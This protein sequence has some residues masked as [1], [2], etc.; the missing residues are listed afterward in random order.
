MEATS[1]SAAVQPVVSWDFED[2]AGEQLT[3]NSG[4]GN[5]GTIHGATWVEIDGG[6]AL[7]FD[8]VGLCRLRQN[9][10][11]RLAGAFIAGSV[12]QPLTISHEPTRD[13]IA[14]LPETAPDELATVV[15]IRS[16]R[17]TDA[18]HETRCPPGTAAIELPDR[19]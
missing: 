14:G 5:H 3:D 6:H 16:R 10:G 12:G 4:N 18:E 11:S 19:Q 8:G 2:A 7:R 13:V 15:R 17:K 9:R 1:T